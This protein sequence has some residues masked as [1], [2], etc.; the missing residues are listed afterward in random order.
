MRKII[1]LLILLV[2]VSQMKAQD[3]P[4]REQKRDTLHT[5]KTE[6]KGLMYY[7][8]KCTFCSDQSGDCMKH[9]AMLI[10]TGQYYCPYCYIACSEKSDKEMK[11]Y[12]DKCGKKGKM[13][14]GPPKKGQ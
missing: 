7:C 2:S 1:L 6:K 4:V 10:A 8:P 13:M 12:C 5:E 11:D 14:Q 9:N 3:K